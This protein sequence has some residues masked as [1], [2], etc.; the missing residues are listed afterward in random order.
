MIS[1]CV[2]TGKNIMTIEKK[3]SCVER[4]SFKILS[5]SGFF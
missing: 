4:Y 2:K 1:I 5:M 3:A